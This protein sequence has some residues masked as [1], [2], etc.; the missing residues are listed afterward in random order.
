M[1]GSGVEVSEPE[2]LWG[3]IGRG[4]WGGKSGSRRGGKV[5]GDRDRR[6]CPE[7]A[8]EEEEERGLDEVR[9]IMGSGCEQQ[10]DVGVESADRRGRGGNGV[11]KELME[12]MEASRRG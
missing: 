5:E 7:W 8:P 3:G 9:V 12:Q 6:E 2:F 4:I 11:E 10:G 1:T